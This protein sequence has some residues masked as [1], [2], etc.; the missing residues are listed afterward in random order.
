LINDGPETVFGEVSV[1]VDV[2][3]LEKPENVSLEFYPDRIDPVAR[4]FEEVNELYSKFSFVFEFSR[5]S[6]KVDQFTPGR[7]ISFYFGALAKTLPLEDYRLR[8]LE[9]Q[10]NISITPSE[11]LGPELNLKNNSLN[12][13]FAVLYPKNLIPTKGE[14]Y[15]DKNSNGIPDQGEGLQESVTIG[16]WKN[17]K[18]D[19]STQPNSLGQFILFL[20]ENVEQTITLVE[21]PANLILFPGTSESVTVVPKQGDTIPEI[22]FPLLD[23]SQ[24]A[25]VELIVVNSATDVGEGE[26]ASITLQVTNKGPAIATGLEGSI[27]QDGFSIN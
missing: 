12:G 17:G 24:S 9:I 11:P 3:S 27:E 2:V 21:K 13:S 10:A 23:P 7:Q 25:D 18:L 15:V 20:E 8:D 19:D 22:L 5:L 26:T 1:S 6:P 14:T 4:G 16:L